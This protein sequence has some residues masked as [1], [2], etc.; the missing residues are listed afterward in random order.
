MIAQNGDIEVKNKEIGV[1]FEIYL[2][3]KEFDSVEIADDQNI[4]QL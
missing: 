4:I 3:L 1:T 2:P